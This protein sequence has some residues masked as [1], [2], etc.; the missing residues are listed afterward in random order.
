MHEIRHIVLGHTVSD[1]RSGIDKYAT[2]RFTIG[3]LDFTYVLW[4]S[5]QTAKEIAELYN[6]SIMSAK[7]REKRIQDLYDFKNFLLH[8]LNNKF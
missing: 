7:I 6:I 8:R 4:R 3:V 5:I 1:S 2:E